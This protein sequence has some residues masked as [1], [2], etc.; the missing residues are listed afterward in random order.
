MSAPPPAGVWSAL[1]RRNYRLFVSGQLVSLVGTWTQSVAQTWL[2]FRLTG[3][4]LWLGIAT[5]CQQAPA[6]FLATAGGLV[7]DRHRRRAVLL[8][9]Q[10]AAMVLAFAL[11]ALTL[12]GAVRVEHLLVFAALL[13]AINAVDSPTRQSFVIEMV[14]RE[15]LAGAGAFNSSMAVGATVIGPAIAGVAIKALGEGWCFLANGVSFVAVIAGLAAMRDLPAPAARRPRESV[16]SRLLEG[17]RFVAADP[18]ARA[19]LALLAVTAL[20]AIPYAT[21][22]PV[23]ASKV[24]H[25]D[26]RTYGW[27]MGSSGAGAL[28]AGLT[29]ASRESLQGTYRWIGASCGA[30]GVLLVLFALS[31]SLWLSIAI[32]LPIGA[33]TMM[34]VNATNTVI[35]ALTPDALRGRVMA[36]WLMI[37]MGFAPVGSILAGWLATAFNPSLPLVAGGAACA[38]A[39]GSWVGA[40]PRA[41][42]D[43]ASVGSRARGYQRPSRRSEAP[44]DDATGRMRTLWSLPL[45]DALGAGSVGAVR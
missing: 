36:V 17:F 27:L 5:F 14:G 23:F 2:V 35:Q 44:V 37:L 40:A 11:A 19:V 34:L 39:A 38:L 24:L 4:P 3:S 1:R 18:R 25:G 13:G 7:A 16:R 32:M 31:R 30:L 33:A 9:T 8:T 41:R 6:F 22:M 28:L 15:N 10:S 42:L 43:R 29:V 12:G 21:L 20:M 45:V 26:A